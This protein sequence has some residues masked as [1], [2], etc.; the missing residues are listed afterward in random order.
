[1]FDELLELTGPTLLLAGSAMFVSVF[2][3]L[4]SGLLAAVKQYTWFDQGMTLF[5]LIGISAPSFWLGLM[6]V[7]L[8]TVQLD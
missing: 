4:I 1:M 8:F 6:A 5:T 2:L 3:G 7:V